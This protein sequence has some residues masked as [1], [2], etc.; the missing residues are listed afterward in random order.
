MWG[1]AT[2]ENGQRWCF[3]SSIIN[4]IVRSRKSRTRWSTVSTYARKNEKMHELAMP[5][6]DRSC[7]Q[8]WLLGR[9][10][11]NSITT[12]LVVAVAGKRWSRKVRSN[13]N[14]GYSRRILLYPL[15]LHVLS[16]CYCCTFL[17]KVIVDYFFRC[18]WQKSHTQKSSDKKVVAAVLLLPAFTSTRIHAHMGCYRVIWRVPCFVMMIS[19]AIGA[20]LAFCYEGNSKQV[21]A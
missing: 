6:I 4:K 1:N 15:L 17:K 7:K 13:G 16:C 11:A 18:F 9:R 14:D 8:W 12:M 10:A 20:C 5:N 21:S 2:S 3:K 19:P